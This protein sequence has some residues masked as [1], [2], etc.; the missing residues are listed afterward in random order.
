MTISFTLLF[1]MAFKQERSTIAIVIVGIANRGT[2][3]AIVMF[4]KR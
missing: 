1:Y 3:I 4:E 2:N